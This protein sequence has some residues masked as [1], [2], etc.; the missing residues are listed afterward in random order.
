[1]AQKYKDIFIN[2]Q[3][4]K[5]VFSFIRTTVKQNFSNASENK[6]VNADIARTSDIKI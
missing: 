1:M 5:E 4:F 2:I 6:F 3:E